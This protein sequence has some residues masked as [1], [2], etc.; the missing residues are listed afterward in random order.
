MMAR[1]FCLAAAM[2]V[3]ASGCS[4]EVNLG[5]NSSNGWPGDGSK[6]VEGAYAVETELVYQLFPN[7]VVAHSLAVAGENVYFSGFSNGRA[8][9]YRCRKTNCQATAERLAKVCDQVGTMQV[10]EQRLAVSAYG[11][12]TLWLGSY[13]LPS[14]S[15]KQVVIESLPQGGNLDPLF[16]GGFVYWSLQEDAAIYRCALPACTNGPERVGSQIN[17]TWLFG[18]GDLIFWLYD[19]FIHRAAQLGSS[20]AQ[21]LLADQ[22]LS[23]AAADAEL[24]ASQDYPGIIATSLGMLYA[25]LRS[26]NPV[27][28]SSDCVGGVVRWPVEGGTRETIHSLEER[29]SRFFVFENELVWI[30]RHAHYPD[31]GTLSS[32]R[33]EACAATRRDLGQVFSELR[34]LARDEHHLYWLETAWIDGTSF[35]EIQ[36]RR[37][38]RL[39]AP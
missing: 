11:D 24:D 32:C 29:V 1:G 18:E 16:H 21:R 3:C 2:A 5:G 28:Q 39:T 20:P 4:E 8:S 26:T 10:Y 7:F 13:A 38:A 27:C 17:D 23:E 30:S 25:G 34:G 12:N 19:G 36:I 15:D 37:V 6:T 9:L 35:S 33:V 31:L 22:T 14:A